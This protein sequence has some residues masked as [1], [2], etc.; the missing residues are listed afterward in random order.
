MGGG[1]SIGLAANADISE[2]KA[3]VELPPVL[4]TEKNGVGR[5]WRY[6]ATPGH[7]ILSRCSDEVSAEF[8]ER[9]MRL[10]EMLAV[11]LPR[12]FQF[13]TSVPKVTILTTPQEV[14][15]NARDLILGLDEKDRARRRADDS[16]IR[17][18]PNLALDDVDAISLFAILDERRADP[19][20]LVYTRLHLQLML[21]RCT[22]APPTWLV[23]GMLRLFEDLEFRDRD[24]VVRP[25]AW[26]MVV[27]GENPRSNSDH[28]PKV[29]AMA[30]M[31]AGARPNKNTNDSPARAQLAAQS[32]LLVRW[33]L[34]TNDSS[35]RDGFWKLVSSATHGPVDDAMVKSC[36]GIDLVELR[37]RLSEY[38]PGAMKTRLRLRLEKSTPLPKLEIEDAT[39]AQIGRI[40]GDWD[41]LEAKYVSTEHP[42]FAPLYFKLAHHAID[43]GRRSEPND[44]ALCAVAG[45]L[46][47]DEKND[48]MAQPFLQLAADAKM[49]RPRV[50]VDLARLRYRQ[51]LEHPAG[52]GGQLSALQAN[53]ILALLA[54][55]HAQLP[56]L[57][58]VYVLTADVWNHSRAS[59]E[60]QNLIMLEN[61]IGQFP[62]DVRLLYLVALLEISHGSPDK[63]SDYLDRGLQVSRTEAVRTRFQQ[64]KD[65]LADKK[66]R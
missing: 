30:D 23:A 36:L 25:F 35:R 26:P 5:P 49:I 29:L 39:P 21:E 51:A 66:S 63:A 8:A 56:P 43:E 45:L 18:L 34:D 60:P 58:D 38:L 27:G 64:L 6:L 65:A 11:V 62:E 47:S 1:C 14:S 53:S 52:A 46:E 41:R 40:I 54:T 48:V 31:F 42:E 13:Q 12:Q 2:A 10:E 9:E 20:A 32:A 3:I 50:Y 19:T 7:E 37:D 59:L 15:A 61:A 33:A 22:P 16:S 55:A 4:V 44:P 57:A 24:I 28:A 17:F